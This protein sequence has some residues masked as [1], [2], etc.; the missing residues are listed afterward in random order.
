MDSRS[1]SL[2]EPMMPLPKKIVPPKLNL[3]LLNRKESYDLDTLDIKIS[4]K[5]EEDPIKKLINENEP[6]N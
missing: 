4:L 1:T 3:A 5:E 2:V 6:K